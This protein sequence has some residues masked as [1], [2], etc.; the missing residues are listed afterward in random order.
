MQSVFINLPITWLFPNAVSLTSY[1]QTVNSQVTVTSTIPA[2]KSVC[3]EEIVFFT[4]ETRGSAV[5]TWTSNTYIGDQIGFDFASNINETRRGS[6]DTN[7]VATL[8]NN[9]DE[10]GQLLLI[11]QLR[12]VVSAVS[13]NPT[14]TCIHGSDGIRYPSMFQVTGEHTAFIFNVILVINSVKIKGG[15]RLRSNLLNRKATS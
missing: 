3:P 2:N 11:S 13:S 12:I 4:C 15:L 5:I 8:I 14:V 1:T 9:T 6:V 10:N 7:T